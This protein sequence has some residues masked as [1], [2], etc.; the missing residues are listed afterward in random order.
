MMVQAGTLF[1]YLA[2]FVTIVLALALSDLLVSVHRL[3]RARKRVR[4]RPL[5]LLL[6]T[7]IALSLLTCFFELWDLTRWT[8]LTY[9]GLVWQVTQYVPVFLAACAV[10]PDDVP[11]GGLDLDEFYFTERRYNVGLL[12]I[13]FLFSAGDY[14]VR[15]WADIL[16]RPE[17][18]N[19]VLTVFLPMNLLS[20]TAFAAI[21]WSRRKWLHWLGFLILFG[22]AHVGYSDWV[23]EGASALVP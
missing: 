12:A 7:F 21:A 5:P 17:V 4:W 9:Y 8:S 14:L 18:S 2:A 15:Q 16:A 3:L 10:L 20:L 22:L 23:V 11:E 1:G 6:A 13:A 19:F